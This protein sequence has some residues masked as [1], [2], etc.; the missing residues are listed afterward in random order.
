MT[1]IIVTAQAHSICD[2]GRNLQNVI[3]GTMAC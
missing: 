1:A 3:G 2:R